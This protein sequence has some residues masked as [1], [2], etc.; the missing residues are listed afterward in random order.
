MSKTINVQVVVD[1]V[2]PW[3]FIG[4]RRLETAIKTFKETH[5]DVTF[6]IEYLPYQLDPSIKAPKN[7]L[8]SYMRKYGEEQTTQHMIPK[9][10]QI[11]HQEGINLTYKGVIANT[12]DSHR[13]LY[14]A[15]TL[16]KQE[17]VLEQIMKLYFEQARDISDHEELAFAAEKA[18]LLRSE[19]L[20]FLKGEGG[21]KEVKALLRLNRI[22]GVHGVPH[23]LFNNSFDIS[24]AQT[25]ET[26]IAVFIN[27]LK[28]SN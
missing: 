20:A 28:R 23:Y 22:K 24:G 26:L 3:C 11:A 13:L 16:N 14:Y 12:L 19:T 10:T 8:E 17:E 25:P 5:P 1:T 27:V 9:M 15:K 7:K 21:T 18:G 2:C 6:E 4:K